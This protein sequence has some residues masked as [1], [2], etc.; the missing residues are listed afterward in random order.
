MKRPKTIIVLIVF[1][2]YSFLRGL[3]R[4]FM[5]SSNPDYY[6]YTE[7]GLSFLFFVISL[8]GLILTGMTLWYLWKPKPIGF[9]L[10]IAGLVLGLI[11]TLIGLVITVVNPDVIRRAMILYR[12]ARG[13]RAPQEVIDSMLSPSG[14]AVTYGIVIGTTLL[15]MALIYWKRDYFLNSE[16]T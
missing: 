1:Y 7:L 9:W 13:L 8:P 3:Q 12:E 15:I 16:E 14:I 6:V 10:A 5:F 11:D 4:A 2:L